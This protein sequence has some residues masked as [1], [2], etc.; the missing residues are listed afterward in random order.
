MQSMNEMLLWLSSS[1]PISVP[2]TVHFGN[3]SHSAM[4][5]RNAITR[6]LRATT[7]LRPVTTLAVRAC[8]SHVHAHKHTPPIATPPF[9]PEVCRAAPVINFGTPNVSPHAASEELTQEVRAGPA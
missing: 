2:D 6:S 4:L 1:R 9:V 3:P 7:P 5:A 8:S